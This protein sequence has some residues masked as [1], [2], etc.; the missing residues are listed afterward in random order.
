MQLAL[1]GLEAAAELLEAGEL[2]TTTRS[3]QAT[4]HWT[5][6]YSVAGAIQAGRGQKGLYVIYR[7]GRIVDSGKADVQDL[8][9]RLAQHFEYPLRH[10]ENLNDYRIRLGIVRRA[11]AV[12]LAE[13]TVTRSLAKRGQ[14]PQARQSLSTG[15]T[16]RVPNTAPFQTPRDR[17]VRLI[18]TGRMPA[19]LRG[20]T[21]RQGGRAVQSIR[22]GQTFEFLP[23]HL[24]SRAAFES[25]LDRVGHALEA[26]VSGGSPPR[27]VRANFVSCNKPSAAIAAVTGPDPVGTIQRAVTRAIQL[28]DNA[29]GE[30]EFTRG[31]IVAGATAGFPTVSDAVGLALQNRFRLDPNSRAVW[32]STAARSVLVLIRRLRGA[33]QILADGWMRYTCLGPPSMTLGGCRA[34]PG[35][36]CPPDR[37][38]RRAVS[39]AGHSQIVLCRAWWSDGVDDQAGTLLHEC[40]H[41]YFGFIGDTGVFGNAHCYEHLVLDLNGLAPQAGFEHACS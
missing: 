11:S 33:R 7:L 6:P 36:T 12:N 1:S 26:E 19:G 32:T 28:L 2:E 9:T 16:T 4:V 24:Q 20:F 22:P 3:G 23:P 15:R 17:G 34:T 13:G 40:F 8:A 25:E 27:P 31:R 29:I 30:L 5:G 35:D 37:P 21:T 18:H 10:A 14:I 39:C 41:I 38:N